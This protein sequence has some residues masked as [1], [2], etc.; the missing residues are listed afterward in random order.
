MALRKFVNFIKKIGVKYLMMYVQDKDLS[1]K[2]AASSG[3]GNITFR[4]A[5]PDQVDPYLMLTEV[6]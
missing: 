6:S 1:A 4:N 5:N 2:I 3:L